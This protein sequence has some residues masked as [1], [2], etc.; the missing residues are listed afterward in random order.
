MNLS[1]TTLPVS[2]FDLTPSSSSSS[3]SCSSSTQEIEQNPITILFTT[4]ITAAPSLP[5]ELIPLIISYTPDTVEAL[6]DT[7]LW[8]LNKQ[9][10]HWFRNTTVQAIQHHR[11]LRHLVS[12]ASSERRDEI[13]N[14][15]NDILCCKASNPTTI[16]RPVLD[17]FINRFS[18]FSPD[19]SYLKDDSQLPFLSLCEMYI[20]LEMYC[21]SGPQRDKAKKI[22]SDLISQKIPHVCTSMLITALYLNRN[23][24]PICLKSTENPVCFPILAYLSD[25]H[26]P[27]IVDATLSDILLIIPQ[28][29][30]SE[31]VEY[32]TFVNVIQQW[33]L[34]TLPQLVK[35][36][37]SLNH[38]AF[39]QILSLLQ[40]NTKLNRHLPARFNED[41]HKIQHDLINTITH[42][43]LKKFIPAATLDDLALICST[44]DAFGFFD[45]ALLKTIE[46]RLL[47]KN[48]QDLQKI[49][50]ENLL[51]IFTFYTNMQS[52][53]PE[54]RKG[55]QH[56]L[57]ANENEKLHQCTFTQLVDFTYRFMMTTRE[58]LV[59]LFWILRELSTRMTTLPNIDQNTVEQLLYI[60][61]VLESLFTNEAAIKTLKIALKPV[62]IPKEDR[63][64]F[65]L[66]KERKQIITC[67][68]AVQ[69]HYP[70]QFR[71]RTQSRTEGLAT[72]F[73]LESYDHILLLAPA[74]EF[75]W[76]TPD[77]PKGPLAS[78]VHLLK[79]QGHRV[80]LISQH[81][82][83]TIWPAHTTAQRPDIFQHLNQF[84]QLLSTIDITVYRTTSE[85]SQHWLMDEYN[86]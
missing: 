5:K 35:N 67:F 57:T 27:A 31:R 78:R 39:L 73:F 3:S 2:S 43:L 76:N 79:T 82:C 30:L 17:I 62:C 28:F 22:L 15:F 65:D 59:S 84:K 75:Y 50:T 54:F 21:Y 13:N 48:G 20:A 64:T 77:I 19:T 16:E 49:S 55:V 68:N 24:Q 18:N 71:Y 51:S 83:R 41:L 25:F 52:T 37:N 86:I 53:T 70:A 36:E 46:K 81:K 38:L 11:Y 80:I 47:D 60:K 29:L 6:A 58:N 33:M 45:E 44:Y 32:V 8:N 9:N 14:Y 26:A 23:Y 12:I 4:I 34:H 7:L 1:S 72:D 10:W 85:P 42:E 66:T 40:M 63:S 74:N 56:A 61:V 69:S